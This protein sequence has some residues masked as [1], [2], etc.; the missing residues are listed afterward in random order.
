M[1]AKEFVKEKYPKSRA[2]RHRLRNGRTYWLIRNRNNTMYIS[3]GKS[4]KNA[5]ENAK[6]KI[7]QE[8]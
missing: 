1:T 2:E 6:K 3:S 7:L 4:E 8:T 5:W